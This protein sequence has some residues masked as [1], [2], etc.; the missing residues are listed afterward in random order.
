M[1]SKQMNFLFNEDTSK[2]TEKNTEKLEV[3]FSFTQLSCIKNILEIKARP[4]ML[5]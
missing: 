1:I 4:E 3:G 5:S 2:N